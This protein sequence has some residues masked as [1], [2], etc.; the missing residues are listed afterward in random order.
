M[1][2]AFSFFACFTSSVNVI[3]LPRSGGAAPRELRANAVA[4]V[5][6]IVSPAAAAA[7][8]RSIALRLIPSSATRRAMTESIPSRSSS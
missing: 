3:S 2:I 1:L 7:E 5:A 8:R 4:G 6:R